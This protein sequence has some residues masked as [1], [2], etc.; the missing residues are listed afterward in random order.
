[1]QLKRQRN[2]IPYFRIKKCGVKVI[3]F[4]NSQTKNVDLD[5]VDKEPS[6][7]MKN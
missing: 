2:F 3:N 1:M 6:D 4:Q 7:Q 5:Y